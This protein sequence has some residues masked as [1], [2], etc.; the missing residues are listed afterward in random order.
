[1]ALGIFKGED[2]VVALAIGNVDD[3][4]EGGGFSAARGARYQNEALG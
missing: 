2:M 3:G 1:M 4:G